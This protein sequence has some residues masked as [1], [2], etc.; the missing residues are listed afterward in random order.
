[1]PAAGAG[2]VSVGGRRAGLVR[3]ARSDSYARV[4][5]LAT[6][7][8]GPVFVV[9]AVLSKIER[10][11]RGLLPVTR[12]SLSR[13]GGAPP[14]RDRGGVT[15]GRGV[16]RRGRA[17]SRPR[18]ARGRRRPRRSCAASRA[19]RRGGARRYGAGVAPA[20]RSR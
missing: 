11:A 3:D 9:R 5:G 12:R 1:M 7:S 14:L 8:A 13:G 6:V 20:R 18:R 10:G 2:I 4:H 17:P 15:G 16:S 19:H